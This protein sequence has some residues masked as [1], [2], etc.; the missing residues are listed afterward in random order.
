M[1][2]TSAF[3]ET[4]QLDFAAASDA[5]LRNAIQL[6]QEE[7]VARYKEALAD[8]AI[9]EDTDGISFRGIPWFS[10]LETAETMIGQVSKYRSADDL[11]RLSY[12]DYS[13][14]SSGADRVD[15]E[16]GCN[17]S[18]SGQN[19]AGYKPSSTCICYIFPI[20]EGQI[21]RE[22]D[23]AQMYM[24]YYEFED[25]DYGDLSSVYDDLQTKLSKLYGKGKS[26]SSKYFTNIVWQD[27]M[28][29]KIRLQIDDDASYLTL[30]YVASAA[31]SRLDEMADACAAEKAQ[32]E[33]AIRQQNINNTDGL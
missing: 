18:Y 32:A 17:I 19:V 7:Q 22:F 14:V 5:E 26:S 24:G 13:S 6:I 23:L 25:E 33:E 31:D 1:I 11:R 29:N 9:P 28:G 21:V 15:G 8:Q 10:S 20:V 2:T 27:E 4:L 3:A 16:L 12:T 30:A